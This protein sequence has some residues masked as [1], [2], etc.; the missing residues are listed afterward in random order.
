MDLNLE[1]Q[2]ALQAMMSGRNI[3]L[4]GNA[5]TGKTTILREFI[6]SG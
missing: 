1:Q 3:F 5:G 6:Q 2:N 4:T